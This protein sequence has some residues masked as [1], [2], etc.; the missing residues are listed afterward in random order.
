M[1]M[2]GNMSNQQDRRNGEYQ[3]GILDTSIIRKEHCRGGQA[4]KP[5]Q[6]THSERYSHIEHQDKKWKYKKKCSRIHAFIR[7]VH[8]CNRA[9]I[10]DL[11]N[12]NSKRDSQILGKHK[13]QKTKETGSVGTHLGEHMSKLV[14]QDCHKWK[15]RRKEGHA[16][17]QQITTQGT[18]EGGWTVMSRYQY[19]IMA[20]KQ[21]QLN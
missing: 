5:Q 12:K 4:Y 17:R 16:G 6:F 2:T 9:S 10:I 14:Q 21:A 15:Y 1:L 11:G 18:K 20:N 8:G 3:T 19:K 7:Q 13:E